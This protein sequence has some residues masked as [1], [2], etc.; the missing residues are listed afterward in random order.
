VGWEGED[1]AASKEKCKL[2]QGWE[3]AQGLA[4]AQRAPRSPLPTAAAERCRDGNTATQW[5]S[6]APPH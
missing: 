2:A 6:S 3:Q 5:G 4:I 1:A